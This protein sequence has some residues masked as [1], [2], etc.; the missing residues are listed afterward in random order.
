MR[1]LRK[2]F[3]QC[4]FVFLSV[5]WLSCSEVN[6][7]DELHINQPTITEMVEE[8]VLAETP[9]QPNDIAAILAKKQIP[10]LCYHHIRDYLPTDKPSAKPYIVPIDVF[11][12]QMKALKDSGYQS[13]LIEDLLNYLEYNQPLPEKA[14]MLTFDDT[15]LNQY[16]EG[17]PIL[18]KYGFKGV[19]FMMTVSI[20]K[21]RYMSKAQ[22]KSLSDKG[23]DV[24]LHTWDHQN[25][26]KLEGKDWETQITKPA[27]TLE[28]ITGKPVIHFAYPFGL[29]KPEVLPILKELGMKSAYQLADKMDSDYPL[30]TIR[31]IIVPG[32]LSGK[33]L[34]IQMNKSF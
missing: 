22:I 28:E 17:L 23:H 16:T 24:Q 5:S 1:L 3:I 15:N 21:E 4:Y 2:T 8:K 14:V 11:D 32:T 7:K 26:K 30:H 34:I 6:E 27:K 19:F 31:R 33:G 25:V 13:I 10:I 29:W 18:E 20:G 9:S 12:A